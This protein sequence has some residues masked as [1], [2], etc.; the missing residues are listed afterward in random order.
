MPPKPPSNT[1]LT[2][3]FQM[4][5]NAS[6][7]I[8]PSEDPTSIAIASRCGD[9]SSPA[10]CRSALALSATLN[11]VRI[12]SSG[13]WFASTSSR[14]MLEMV[15]AGAPDTVSSIPVTCRLRRVSK[16]FRP[17]PTE[18]STSTNTTANVRMIDK[19]IVRSYPISTTVWNME[20]GS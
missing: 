9:H 4:R 11:L 7:T 12:F 16:Y 5:G 13:D 18:D 2:S 6:A 17:M 20:A 8:R 3:V 14:R 1:Q 15:M 19:S 10:C